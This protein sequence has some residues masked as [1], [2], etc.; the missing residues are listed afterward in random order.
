[1]RHTRKSGALGQA[2]QMWNID[3]EGVCR[4]YVCVCIGCCA[5][6]YD[7]WQRTTKFNYITIQ[8]FSSNVFFSLSLLFRVHLIGM[9]LQALGVP[10]RVFFLT[11]SQNSFFRP[12]N[13]GAIIWL[14]NKPC[15]NIHHH[16]NLRAFHL[17]WHLL[18]L[19]SKQILN[20]KVI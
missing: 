3:W 13:I 9:F 1:M 5:Q 6:K 14:S 7:Y 19:F 4:V 18:C 17:S 10:I 2:L 8:S 15:P 20:Q 12:A 11:A 16:S